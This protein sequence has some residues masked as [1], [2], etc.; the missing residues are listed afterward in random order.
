MTAQ[1]YQSCTDFFNRTKFRRVVLRLTVSIL[2]LL[3]VALYVGAIVLL[4]FTNNPRLWR[5]VLVPACLFVTVTVFRRVIN[6]PRPYD[7]LDYTPFVTPR[8]GKGESFPSRHTASACIIALAFGY[9]QP[10]FGAVMGVIAV[11]I[12]VS[13]VLAGAHYPKDVLCGALVS[14]LFGIVG[15]WMI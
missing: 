15:F 4:F 10:A 8:Y 5:F 1:Q 7:E 9:L 12:G 14:L 6:R 3:N 11:L 2:P 13:R